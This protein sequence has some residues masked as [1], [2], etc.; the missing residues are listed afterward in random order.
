MTNIVRVWCALSQCQVSP[1]VS[2]RELRMGLV[3]HISTFSACITLLELTSTGR[4][5]IR[6][7]GD[8]VQFGKLLFRLWFVFDERWE[9][10]IC[11]P[12]NIQRI[13]GRTHIQH[14]VNVVESSLG[15]N[16][17][18]PLSNFSISTKFFVELYFYVLN[19]QILWKISWRYFTMHTTMHAE[20]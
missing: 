2:L 18:N 8:H 4:I 16:N 17:Q 5:S 9:G 12:L 11:S 7:S 10:P 15:K 19:L 3:S 14:F 13:I 1:W 6:P 20:W